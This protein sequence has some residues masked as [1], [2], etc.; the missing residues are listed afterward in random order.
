MAKGQ[1]HVPGHA[2]V[3]RVAGGDKDHAIR[4][5]SAG[6][7]DGTAGGFDAVDGLEL[8]RSVEVPEYFAVLGGI[9]AEVTVERGRKD[10]AWDR[11]DRS[12]LGGTAPD[13]RVFWAGR[14]G[15]VPDLGSVRDA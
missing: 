10:R 8:V 15:C 7:F 13:E 3:T 2:S 9:S 11:A 6:T 14:W 1:Q 5:H 12:R 4:D